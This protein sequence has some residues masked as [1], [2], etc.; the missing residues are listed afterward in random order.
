MREFPI[1]S[2]GQG[3]VDSGPLVLGVSLSAFAVTLAAARANGDASLADTLDREAETFGVGLQWR[4]ERRYA[5]G[6]LPVG[7]AWPACARSTP[8]GARPS[9][10]AASR[11]W[12]WACALLALTP[13]DPVGLWELAARRR[14]RRPAETEA[15]TA[16]W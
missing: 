11:T 8:V 15:T 16:V 9:R 2:A 6:Q 13:A 5:L 14:R 12:W 3:D 4:G 7:D 10:A 1:G